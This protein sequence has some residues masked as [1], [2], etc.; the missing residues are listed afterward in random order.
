MSHSNYGSALMHTHHSFTFFHFLPLSST[1]FNLCM[2]ERG[3]VWEETLILLPDNVRFV[4]LSATIPNALQFA[5]WI[6]ELHKQVVHAA[7]THIHV[8]DWTFAL[9]VLYFVFFVSLVPCNSLHILSILLNPFCILSFR[10][11]FNSHV[12]W[13]TRIIGPRHFVTTSFLRA[14]KAST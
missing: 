5:K 8:L 6:C 2:A 14:A 1:F 9:S 10:F 7:V 11:F 4:F 3:V 13:C 12:T